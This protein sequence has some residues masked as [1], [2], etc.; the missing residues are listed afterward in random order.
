L[1]MFPQWFQ[2][3]V[4]FVWGRYCIYITTF[5]ENMQMG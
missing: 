1:L 3:I 5:S 4:L 2:S